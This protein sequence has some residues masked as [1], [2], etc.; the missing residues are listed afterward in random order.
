MVESVIVRV[1]IDAY[2]DV[3][4]DTRVCIDEVANA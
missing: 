4:R 2:L 1:E 3:A